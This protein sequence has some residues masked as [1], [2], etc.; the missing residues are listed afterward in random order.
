MV[1]VKFTSPPVEFEDGYALSAVM[2]NLLLPVT[3]PIC[4]A[5]VNVV[6]APEKVLM[7]EASNVDEAEPPVGHVVLQ[8]K[9][10]VKQS[11]V[12]ENSVDVAFENFCNPVQV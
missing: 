4:I 8:G 3:L 1:L 10:P 9:S 11:V 12:A 2:S 7:S 6:V 5:P